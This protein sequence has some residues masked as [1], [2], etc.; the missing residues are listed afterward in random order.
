MN[1]Q[2]TS[3]RGFLALGAVSL[4]LAGCGGGSVPMGGGST[5][6]GGG[7]GGLTRG[8]QEIVELVA[9]GFSAH[10]SGASSGNPSRVRRNGEPTFDT[11]Y[12]L[13]AKP[14]EDGVDYFEDE[15]CTQPAGSNRYRR[16][17]AENG[18]D[19]EASGT[20]EITAGPKAGARGTSRVSVSSVDGY[21]YWFLFEGSIPGFATYKTEGRWDSEGGG[22]EQYSEGADGKVTRYLCFYRPDGTSRVEFTGSMGFEFRL[23]FASDRSGTGSVTGSNTELLPA[24]VEWDASGSGSVVF[25][26]GSRVM[27]ENFQFDTT[28]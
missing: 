18:S 6:S 17:Y 16:E 14:V 1:L 2:L 13:W 11:F 9:G 21:V 19:M 5:G 27:F 25:Q 3:R 28:R 26:D 7:G 23:E 4:I 8:K 12:E 20:F 15:A 10:Q 24:T 22:Y